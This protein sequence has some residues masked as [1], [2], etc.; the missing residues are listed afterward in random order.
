MGDF[1]V[2]EKEPAPLVT[3]DDTVWFGKHKDKVI[4]D[5]IKNEDGGS[6]YIRWLI[7]QGIIELDCEGEE[8]VEENKEGLENDLPHSYYD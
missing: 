5:I 7:E 2:V 1:K 8:F 4:R 3:L 6:Q